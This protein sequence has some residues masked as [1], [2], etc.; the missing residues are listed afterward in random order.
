[1]K[2]ISNLDSPE[3]DKPVEDEEMIEFNEKSVIKWEMLA[4]KYLKK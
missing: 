1:M 2:W 3:A 4:E